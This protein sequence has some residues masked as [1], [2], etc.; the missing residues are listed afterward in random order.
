MFLIIQKAF[1]QIKIHG[2]PSKI[3]NSM[4]GHSTTKTHKD[5]EI[6]H[7]FLILSQNNENIKQL[8]YIFGTE[9]VLYRLMKSL[10]ICPIVPN[11]NVSNR[12]HSQT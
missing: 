8:L 11:L 9:I 1:K 6:E 7:F 2:V 12:Y 4:V 3:G 5:L 10:K